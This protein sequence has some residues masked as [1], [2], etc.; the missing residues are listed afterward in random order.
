MFKRDRKNSIFMLCLPHKRY[1]WQDGKY[2]GWY[3]P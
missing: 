2:I 3:R 1:M